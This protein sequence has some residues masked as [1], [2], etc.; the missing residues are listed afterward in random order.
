MTDDE[1]DAFLADA[2]AE[3]DAKQSALA[4]AFG[5]GSHERFEADFERARIQ[6]R[7]DGSPAAEAT[8]VPL[9]SYAPSSETLVWW[10]TNRRLPDAVRAHGYDHAALAAH[11]GMDVFAQDAIACGE[12][13]GLIGGGVVA[14]WL[15]NQDYAVFINSVRVGISTSDLVSGLIKPLFFGLIIGSVAWS[16]DAKRSFR[17]RADFMDARLIQYRLRFSENIVRSANR[18][19]HIISKRSLEIL[20][21]CVRLLTIRLPV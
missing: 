13:M 10:R 1:F 14:N 6:F 8:I 9:A 21:A 2:L 17:F 18:M 16:P 3:L 12:D 4:A 15:Y 7:D 19:F 20:K 11:T 5:L